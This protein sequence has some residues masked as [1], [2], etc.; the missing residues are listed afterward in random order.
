MGNLILNDRRVDV[1]YRWVIEFPA[2]SIIDR[3]SLFEPL[4][5]GVLFIDSMEHLAR[6]NLT[7]FHR[8]MIFRIFTNFNLIAF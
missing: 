6:G 4:Q 2:P 1:Q 8:F 3:Q 7:L 5:T